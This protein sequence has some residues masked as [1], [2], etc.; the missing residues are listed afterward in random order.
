V[1]RPLAATIGA[2]SA[3]LG[4]DVVDKAAG[5]GLPKAVRIP[6]LIAS[7]R[8]AFDRFMS[9]VDH[10]VAVC[11]WVDDLL[12]RNGVQPEKI[13]LSRQGVDQPAAPSRTRVPRPIGATLR[14][15]YFGR[16][17]RAKGPDL[18]ARA[19]ALIPYV[20]VRV[21]FFAV[22]QD[23]GK[24]TDYDWLLAQGRAD[25]RLTLNAPI[26]P[27]AVIDT[28]RDYDLIVVPSRWLETGPLVVLQAFAAGVP[29][30]G[31]DLGG[32]VEL[33]RNGVDGILVA[34]DDPEAWANT[35]AQLTEDR[36]MVDALRTGIA[37]PRSMD[38]AADDMVNIYSGLLDRPV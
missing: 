10:V 34:A 33:V 11:Q 12:V 20:N 7:D 32:I 6:A 37:P 25:M 35:I 5:T 4:P 23:W 14:L 19:L 26:P 13:T 30:L 15:A 9:K 22:R 27:D 8:R 16:I 38:A 3:A 36:G 18:L 2:L 28:M 24:D 1:W 29:V 17:E 21:D 31:A